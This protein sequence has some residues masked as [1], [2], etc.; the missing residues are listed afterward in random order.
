MIDFISFS[1][2]SSGIKYPP[3]LLRGQIFIILKLYCLYVNYPAAWWLEIGNQRLSGLKI[4]K[5]K[6]I[7]FH[8][9][10]NSNIDKVTVLNLVLSIQINA[11]DISV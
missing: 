4:S 2:R 7:L 1:F 3:C 8:S 10:V 11:A 5:I 6:F 9:H